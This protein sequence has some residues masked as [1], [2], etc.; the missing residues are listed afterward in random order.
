MQIKTFVEYYYRQINI[1]F[2]ILVILTMIINILDI[3]FNVGENTYLKVI[4]I[5]TVV[6]LAITLLMHYRFRISLNACLIIALYTIVINL[7]LTQFVSE[8]PADKL[9]LLLFRETVFLLLMLIFSGLF[10]HK[11]HAIIIF[12]FLIFRYISLAVSLKPSFL[13]ENL[14]SFLVTFL[15]IVIIVYLFSGN[16]HKSIKALQ[17]K[18]DEVLRANENLKERTEELKS[19]VDDLSI[20]NKKLQE[21][22]TGKDKF[23]S[24]ISHDLRNPLN[25][26]RGFTDVMIKKGNSLEQDK[27]ELYL[28]KMRESTNSLNNLLSDLLEWSRSQSGRLKYEPQPFLMQELADS[29]CYYLKNVAE[30]KN[31]TLFNQVDE[32]HT[33]YADFNMIFTVLRNLVSNAIKFSYKGKKIRISTIVEEEQVITKVIDQGTGIR[34]E[35]ME[36]IFDLKTHLSS[37]GTDNEKGTG[38]GL[39]LCKEFVENNRGMLAFES[40][41]GKGSTFW[42]SLPHHRK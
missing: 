17:Q 18:Q 21:M 19:A 29:V 35:D 23:F 13:I 37:P 15:A 33:V 24:I 28:S 32:R 34:K 40:K 1:A 8:R 26:M 38:L 6:I 16:L 22:N 41:E 2:A 7:F 36:K 14:P 3:Y 30:E 39:I 9:L 10:I 25:I 5:G 4:N 11:F 27:R 12:I 31:I 42:F 20:K